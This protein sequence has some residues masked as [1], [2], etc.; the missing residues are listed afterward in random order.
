MLA[1]TNFCDW[2]IESSVL[3]ERRRCLWVLVFRNDESKYRDL[4]LLAGTKYRDWKRESERSR[5]WLPAGTKDRDWKLERLESL[6]LGSMSFFEEQQ[7]KGHHPVSW[8][9]KKERE[10]VQEKGHHP[11]S[12]HVKRNVKMWKKRT[13]QIF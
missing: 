13:I 3:V 7:E 1:G 4:P 11:V 12:W 5:S 8:H 6:G 9:V 2:K 10:D